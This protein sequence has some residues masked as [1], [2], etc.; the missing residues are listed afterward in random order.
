MLRIWENY[1]TMVL[2]VGSR[3]YEL[4]GNI[5][6]PEQLSALSSSKLFSGIGK[7]ELAAFLICLNP[8]IQE[9]EKDDFIAIAGEPLEGIGLVLSGKVGILKE[10]I[11]GNRTIL[12]VLRQ[13][14][15]FGE[16]AAWGSGRR[17]PATALAMEPC[18]V[19]FIP[20][21]KLTGQC[22]RNCAWHKSIIGN[23][24]GILAEKAME[25]NRK[26]ELLEIKSMRG[27]LCAY[28]YD[29]Y[30]RAGSTAFTLPLNRND[31]ADY[32][33]VSRP[34]MSREMGRM[35]DEGIIDFHLSSVLI[36]D[37]KQ[38]QSAE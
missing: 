6:K 4:K 2:K 18:C 37:V 8:R 24:L 36:K 12:S 28:F 16:A 29:L 17:W 30:K 7:E 25:L 27:K 11:A 26:M 9:Y 38:I 19:L 32:L 22:P 31:L 1:N 20:P 10:S 33:D 5:V 14:N 3:G 15:L 35:R 21:E 34:S 23:M 13:G